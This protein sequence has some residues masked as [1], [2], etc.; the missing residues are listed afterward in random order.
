MRRAPATG[1]RAAA[2]RRSQ[3]G[4]SLMELL[5]GIVLTG[6]FSLALYGFFFSGV[7]PS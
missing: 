2:R 4:F 1:G 5:M 6:I 7:G 3:S